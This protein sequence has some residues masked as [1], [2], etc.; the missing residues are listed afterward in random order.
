MKL[1]CLQKDLLKGL[2]TVS[3]AVATRSTLPILSNVMLVAASDGLELVATDLEISIKAIVTADVDIE[4]STTVPANTLTD[5]VNSLSGETVKMELLEMEKLK[6]SCGRQRANIKGVS[7]AEFPTISPAQE[8]FYLETEKLLR[9]VRRTIISAARDESRPILEGVYFSIENNNLT[10][11]AAD[12]FRLSVCT[13]HVPH[14]QVNT[15]IIPA[16]AL[17]ELARV[18]EASDTMLSVMEN[19]VRFKSGNVSIISQLI[20][21]NF[22]DYEQIIPKDSVTVVEV[23]AEGFRRACS[24]ASIFAR[25]SANIA[26]VTV[27]EGSLTVAA[28]SAEHGDSTATIDAKVEGEP[29]AFAISVQYLLDYLNTVDDVVMEIMTPSSPIKF[30]S[31][32]THIIMPMMLSG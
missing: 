32:Y 12:G 24:T 29:I 2:K 11:A 22:P 13:A 25:E 10:L 18:A 23:D 30:S 8:G 28:K 27:G 6:L 17:K 19:Q 26:T 16:R 3:K 21:G 14:Q 5:W 1:S 15:I 20:D 31:E 4:G 7:A 9:M